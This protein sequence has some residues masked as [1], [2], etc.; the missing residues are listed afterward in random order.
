MQKEGKFN[1]E[2]LDYQEVRCEIFIFRRR[3]I[4]KI[5]NLDDIRVQN[6]EEEINK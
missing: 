2:E 3:C 1:L 5:R 6:V 4:S